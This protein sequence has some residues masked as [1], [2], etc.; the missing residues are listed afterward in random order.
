MAALN[1][2]LYADD[3]PD[4]RAMVQVA[5]GLIGGFTVTLCA[6]GA[7]AVEQAASLQ[8]DLVLLDVMMPDLSGPETLA[9]LRATPATAA[10]PVVFMTSARS[11][12]AGGLAGPGVLGVVAKPFDPMSLADR[13]RAIWEKQ[14]R[15]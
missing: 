7:E 9:R 3:E 2:I 14:A 1:H 4:L 6:S 12:E 13:L 8:P 5:L 10:I 11:E 15:T